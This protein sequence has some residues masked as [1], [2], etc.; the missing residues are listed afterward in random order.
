VLRVAYGRHAFLLAGD[1]E[2][3]IEWRMLDAGELRHADVLKVAHHGSKTSTTQEFLGAVSPAFAVISAGLDN[4]YGHPHRDV[5]ERLAERH[6]AVFRT[7]RDG[8]V[9]ILSD[10]RRLRAETHAAEELAAR[11]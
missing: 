8:L 6:T 2:R 5:V 9:T 1:V 10:G 4:S 11:R 3:P 7:D